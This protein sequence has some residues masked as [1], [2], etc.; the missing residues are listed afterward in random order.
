M[1]LELQTGRFYLARDYCE[2]IEAS[3]GVPVHI[4]LIPNAEYIS[5]V[6]ADLDG[7][8]L[9]GSNTDI[10]PAHYG[11]E[12]HPKLGTVI[13]IK[14]TTDRL[15]LREVED[16]GMPLLGICYG[17]QALNVMRGGS[18][19]QD[20]GTALDAGLKHD[21][22]SPYDRPSHAI[23]V[24]DDG[25]LCGLTSRIIGSVRVNSSHH[26]AVRQVG[27]NLR[28]TA[29][30]SDG[31][32]ECI[33]DTRPERFVFGVQWHPEMTFSNDELSR[34]IFRKFVSTCSGFRTNLERDSY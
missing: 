22:G 12:P 13:S 7:V 18:L 10:D 4:A 20:I 6:L 27:K 1:R 34:E 16:L 30:A 15:V 26:Q 23:R 14:D 29:W 31:V 9:P 25:I 33:E 24:A 32:I 11:E 8:L 28:A 5:E 21:Q 19:I 3:G 2:A 17:M